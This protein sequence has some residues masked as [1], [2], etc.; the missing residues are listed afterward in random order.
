MI[1]EFLQYFVNNYNNWI[2]LKPEMQ[3]SFTRP[4]SSG[5]LRVETKKCFAEFN[6]WDSMECEIII[7]SIEKKGEIILQEYK[8]LNSPQ[9][10]KEYLDYFIEEVVSNG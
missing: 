5:F 9:E 2:Y 6:F 1:D 3:V 8:I 4:K 10:I 7:S